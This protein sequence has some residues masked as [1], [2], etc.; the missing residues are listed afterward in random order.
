MRIIQEYSHAILAILAILGAVSVCLSYVQRYTQSKSFGIPLKLTHH[1]VHD[2]V[3][4]FVLILMV[5]L[6]NFAIPI[7]AALSDLSIEVSTAIIML[8][9]LVGAVTIISIVIP[10][11]ELPNKNEARKKYLAYVKHIVLIIIIVAAVF[12]M[13]ILAMIGFSLI[14]EMPYDDSLSPYDDSIIVF[15]LVL[16]IL[17]IAF[18]ITLLSYI[19]RKKYIKRK[20]LFGRAKFPM[21]TVINQKLYMIAM[22]HTADMWILLPCEQ[23][24]SAEDVLCYDIGTFL[25]TS[26]DSLIIEQHGYRDILPKQNKSRQ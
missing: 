24:D 3:G 19:L 21:T 7:Y 25:I 14:S 12:F 23:S 26:L 1:N 4:F 18:I 16:V 8:S 17:Y 13:M 20:K 11:I 10:N 9:L 6:A 2:S 15:A 22:R 5:A